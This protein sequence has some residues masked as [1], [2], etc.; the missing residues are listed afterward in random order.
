MFM[1]RFISL[2]F[3]FMLVTYFTSFSQ[4]TKVKMPFES[5]GI[6]VELQSE[7][8]LYGGTLSYAMNSDIHLGVNF[9]LYF[10]GGAEGSG[11]ST[12]LTFGPYM[13]YF[14]SNM[15]IKSFFPY[16]K[17]QFLVTTT[18]VPTYD[19]FSQK[20]RR[21]TETGTKLILYVGSE[22]FPIS[23]MGIYGGMRAFEIQ[24][25]PTR[26][27]IGTMSVTLGIEWFL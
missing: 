21:V 25:D 20:W 11:S 3:F 12:F 2:F 18:S 6:G 27:R 4:E 14:L 16:L 19:V 15:R 17:G 22:W 10:D 5:F 23:S 13:K 24:F 8:I 1:K 7:D 26:L 9:G